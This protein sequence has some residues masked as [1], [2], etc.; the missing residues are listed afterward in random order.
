VLIKTWLIGAAL[1]AAGTALYTGR[2]NHHWAWD[3]LLWTS[4]ATQA[5]GF[6]LIAPLA[7]DALSRWSKQLTGLALL[8]DFLGHMCFLAAFDLMILAVA[9]RLTPN[10]GRIRGRVEKPSAIAA[11]TMLTTFMLA[12]HTRPYCGDFFACQPDPWLR[13][14]W[15]IFAT[16]GLYLTAVLAYLLQA[17]RR[18]YPESRHIAN[19]Y[20]G[21]TTA[22][23]ITCA[24]ILT[25]SITHINPLWIWIPLCTSSALSCAAGTWTWTKNKVQ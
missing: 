12:D 13:A 3:R 19:L 25:N 24:T 10:P 17:I 16:I 2:R 5:T 23:A 15:A 9:Y 14:Y 4:I 20:T 1:A 6:I 21:A 18:E 11:A 22:G 8:P 7:Q